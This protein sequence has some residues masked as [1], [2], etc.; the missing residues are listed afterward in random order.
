MHCLIWVNGT[1][2]VTVTPDI[3][4]ISLGVQDREPTV[5]AAEANINKAMNDVINV[6]KSNNIDDKDIQT[7]QISI[8]PVY[9][10]SEPGKQAVIVAYEVSN[11]VSV[12]VRN[13]ANAGTIIDAVA[14]AGGNYTRINGISFA[15]DKPEQYYEQAR[16]LAMDDAHTRGSQLAS[17]AKVT[18][19][20]PTY[21]SESSN[22]P[23]T[24]YFDNA[25][26]AGAASMP[27]SAGTTEITINVSVTYAIR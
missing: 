11:I 10:N 23:G 2:K 27:V 18:L 21:I 9:E 5:A 15:V 1:G 17:L 8:S 12:K 7:Q 6:L 14:T 26:V 24:V 20:N 22:N 4:T 3:M 16:Q 19:G 25:K 13:I